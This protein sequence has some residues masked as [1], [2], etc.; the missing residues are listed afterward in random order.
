MTLKILD[1]FCGMGGWSIPF[2]EDGDFV[3]GID[4]VDVGYPGELI[5]QDVRTLD[6]KRFRGF[7]LI[8]GSPPCEEFSVAKE[9]QVLKGKPRNVERGLELVK[10]FFRIVDE[11]KPKFYAMENVYR[12]TKYWNVKPNW[13]FYISKGGKRGLWTNIPIGL[14]PEFRFHTRIYLKYGWKT[15]H[16]RS[17]IPYPIARFIADQVKELIKNGVG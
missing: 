13:V 8:I 9:L 17:K 7:D 15:R 11:A 2:I 5:L 10:H 1:L 3:V 16:E 4:I 12:L 6:G 14:A